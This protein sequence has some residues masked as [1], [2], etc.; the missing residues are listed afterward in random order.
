MSNSPRIEIRPIDGSSADEKAFINFPKTLYRDCDRYVPFFDMD[1]RAL[2]RKKHP[3]FQ[4]SEGEFL[5]LW[6]G[7]ELVGR[8]LI[9]ENRRYNDFHKTNFAFFDYFD[10]IN[11]LELAKTLFDY[12]T[13][14]AEGRGLDAVVGPML[15]GGADG[16]G[17]LVKGFDQQPAMTMMRYNH[18]YYQEL[19]EQAGFAKYVDLHSFSIPP[20]YFNLPE[21]IARLAETVEK[22]G[23]FKVMRFKTKADVRKVVEDVKVLYAKTLNHH[24]EDYPLS[25]EEL[26]Q[27]KKDLLTVIDPELIALLTYDGRIIG[28]ALGFAD[29]TST[30]QRNGGRLGPFSI[31]RLIRAMKKTDKVLFNGIGILPEYQGRGGNALLYRELERMVHSRGFRSI[32]MVQISEKTDLMIKDAASL[33]AKPFKVHRLYKRQ[34]NT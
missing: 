9:T 17:I 3:F 1:M 25:P 32:E 28:Y 29:I 6:R 4:H 22:R 34:V 14:W 26:E 20:E 16:A 30:L 19:L 33:R 8:C 21:R 11:D 27:V 13:S 12:L 10:I 5:L 24:L 23:R 18:P 2:L 7:E 15:T 31:L